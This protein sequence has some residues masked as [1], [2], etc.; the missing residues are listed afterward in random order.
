MDQERRTFLKIVLIGSG[1]LLAGKILNPL[2]SRRQNDPIMAKIS[3]HLNGPSDRTKIDSP[4]KSDS[5]SSSFKV[6]ENEK[7]LSIYDNS[8][9]EI[10]QI[11]KE[12]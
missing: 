10:F 3:N 7:I 5:F 2:F 9:E 12:A 1:T 11:D 4:K 6:V 8:G